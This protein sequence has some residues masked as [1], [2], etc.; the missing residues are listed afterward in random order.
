ML[1]GGGRRADPTMISFRGNLMR[2]N[3]DGSCEVRLD[4]GHVVLAHSLGPWG[5][6]SPS[7]GGRVAVELSTHELKGWRLVRQP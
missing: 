2:W 3:I 5:E 4:N 7:P 6:S 1:D